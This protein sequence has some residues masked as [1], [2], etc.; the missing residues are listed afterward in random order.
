MNKNYNNNSFNN[1]KNFSLDAEIGEMTRQEL[2]AAKQELA[3]DKDF[4]KRERGKIMVAI[5]LRLGQLKKPVE[6][7]QTIVSAWKKSPS[8]PS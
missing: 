5:D 1:S 4:P 7:S 3:D 6:S 8:K 2:I